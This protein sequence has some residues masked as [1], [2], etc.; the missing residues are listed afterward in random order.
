MAI[1]L[2][3]WLNSIGT[4]GANLLVNDEDSIKDYVP[5]VINKGMSQSID[6]VI[7]ANEMNKVPWLDPELQYKFLLN[8]VSKKKRYT[9]WTKAEPIA[10]EEE[11]EIISNFFNVNSNVASSYHVLLKPE[12]LS[13]IKET[14]YK[15]GAEGKAIKTK[16]KKAK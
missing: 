8:S 13:E 9:K 12:Q 6:T 14:F 3:D 1:G 7:F 2:M 10:N 11:I 15:G 16:A 5:F 4:S